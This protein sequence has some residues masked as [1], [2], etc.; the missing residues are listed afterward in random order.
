[1]PVLLTGTELSPCR[2][3][4]ACNAAISFMPWYMQCCSWLH[5]M[6]LAMLQLA[7][8][9]ACCGWLHAMLQIGCMPYCGLAVCHAAGGCLVLSMLRIGCMLCCRWLL[10]ILGWLHFMLPYCGLAAC[11]DVDGCMPCCRCHVA[12]GCMQCSG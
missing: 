2:Q 4:A 8:C 12:G 1:M 5:A 9:H 7:A 11:Y 6:L 3:V 10:A